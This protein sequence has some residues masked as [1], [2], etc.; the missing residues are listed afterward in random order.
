MKIVAFL[1]AYSKILFYLCSVIINQLEIMNATSLIG[2][3]VKAIGDC[4]ML[5][6]CT[7][8]GILEYDGN[9]FTVKSGRNIASVNRSSVEAAPS[10]EYHR[11][12][13]KGEIKFGEGAT[14]YKFFEASQYLKSN[15]RIKSWLVCPIDGL[16]YYR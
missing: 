9:I 15:G 8:F 16:R 14:H 5:K 7:V 13:T 10:I 3:Y 1:F 11:Q 2:K 6:G 4:G 12:P